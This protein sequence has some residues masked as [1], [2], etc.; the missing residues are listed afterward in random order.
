MRKIW[1]WICSIFR[2]PSTLAG[3]DERIRR[4][5]NAAIFSRTELLRSMQ[6]LDVKDGD[7]VVIK[8]RGKMSS[9]GYGRFREVVEKTLAG[10]GMN[11]HVMVFEEVD[12]IGILRKECVVPLGSISPIGVF[13]KGSAL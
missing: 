2:R 13:H 10:W 11:V 1:K 8:L 5:I 4:S 12:D 6:K 7:I 9:V 3:V